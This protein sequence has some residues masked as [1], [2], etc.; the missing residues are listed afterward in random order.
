MYDFFI[1]EIKKLRISRESK[2][3]LSVYFLSHGMI[4]LLISAV[5][6]DDWTVFNQKPEV[7][8]KVA[9]MAGLPLNGHLKALMLASGN[10]L[11][12]Y[13]LLTFVCFMVA[14]LALNSTLKNFK[15]IDPKTRLVV[16][17]LFLVLPLY[18]AR[19]SINTIYYSIC[20]AFFFLG[21]A[22]LLYHFRR[23]AFIWRMVSLF[24]FFLSFGT[25]SFLV[26]YFLPTIYILISKPSNIA[27][28][29][30]LSKALRY[31]DFI[32]LPIIFVTMKLIYFM[33]HGIHADYNFI[34]VSRLTSPKFFEAF[35]K[36]FD[37]PFLISNN[38]S[39][40]IIIYFFLSAMLIYYV[41]NKFLIQDREKRNN[42]LK[43]HINYIWFAAG[44]LALMLALYPY[45]V[46]QHMP[47]W[48]DWYSRHQISC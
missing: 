31:A 13:R 26:F 36:I 39:L 2:L 18:G 14:G 25:H 29:A 24:C 45:L 19:V 40:G 35:Q 15:S 37:F 1:G 47:D 10:D 7:L 4:F 22:T 44:M 11:F 3:I 5:F 30:F 17:V 8:L 27:F 20:N 32:L 33:P 38:F 48:H 12:I 41:F 23:N 34:S 21:F 6:W 9:D 42:L 28:R 46:T 16:V 43:S